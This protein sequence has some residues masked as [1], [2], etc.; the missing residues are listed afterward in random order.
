MCIRYLYGFFA[1]PDKKFCYSYFLHIT[2]VTSINKAIC[3]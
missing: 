3:K 1:D 2:C